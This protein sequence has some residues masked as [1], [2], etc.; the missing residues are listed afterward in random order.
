MTSAAMDSFKRYDRGAPRP[1]TQ[2]GKGARA[3]TA[4]VVDRFAGD[5]AAMSRVR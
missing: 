4:R 1:A 5:A 3:A 2:R